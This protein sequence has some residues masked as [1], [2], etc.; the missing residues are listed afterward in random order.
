MIFKLEKLEI[1]SDIFAIIISKHTLPS[2]VMCRC[3]L[4]SSIYVRKEGLPMSHNI[5]FT[6]LN[7]VHTGLVK[8]SCET[9]S[10]QE[11]LKPKAH[12]NTNR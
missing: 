7:T 1:L 10:C 5:I 6:I 2:L 12:N 3:T 8:S 4:A 9:F 11:S